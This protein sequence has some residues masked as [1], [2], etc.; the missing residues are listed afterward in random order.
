MPYETVTYVTV[1]NCAFCQ[2]TETVLSSMVNESLCPTEIPDNML[3][4][5]MA[6]DKHRSSTK[7][8]LQASNVKNGSQH[9]TPFTILREIKATGLNH[10]ILHVIKISIILINPQEVT[11]HTVQIQLMTVNQH[12]PLM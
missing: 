3:Y 6:G 4:V 5:T 9:S 12:Q 8:L 1:K 10:C 11:L 7:I 2:S